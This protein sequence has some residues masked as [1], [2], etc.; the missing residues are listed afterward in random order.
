MSNTPQPPIDPSVS[1]INNNSGTSILNRPQ[2]TSWMKSQSVNRQEE[3]QEQNKADNEQKRSSGIAQQRVKMIGGIPVSENTGLYVALSPEAQ[4]SLTEKERFNTSALDENSTGLSVSNFQSQQIESDKRVNSLSNNDDST[5]Q[6]TVNNKEEPLINPFMPTE[7]ELSLQQEFQ[8]TQY[9]TSTTVDDSSTMS[10]DS[11][12]I[13]GKVSSIF[14]IEIQSALNQIQSAENTQNGEDS[15]Y[16]DSNYEYN[17]DNIPSEGTQEDSDQD[18]PLEED[19]DY[20][21]LTKEDRQEVDRLKKRDAEV[22]AH[23]MAHLAAAGGLATGPYYEYQQGPDSKQYAVGGHV[24]IDT[25]PGNSPEETI[26]KAAKIRS[27]AMAPVEPSSQDRIVAAQAA[28][29]EAAARAELASEKIDEQEESTESETVNAKNIDSDNIDSDT[30]ENK[31]Y[32]NPDAPMFSPIQSDTSH[33]SS[34]GP[35][36]SIIPKKSTAEIYASGFSSIHPIEDMEEEDSNRDKDQDL[37]GR[38]IMSASDRVEQS[39]G[40]RG[41]QGYNKTKK[42]TEDVG[43]QSTKRYRV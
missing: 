25:S 20:Q 15:N 4:K 6:G 41:I 28:R 21:G 36:I 14:D 24:N 26:M 40:I 13:E 43:I 39:R 1:P 8:T 23:E 9:N 32:F 31:S 29:M 35:S 5:Q 18:V 7:E 34:S 38:P 17:D 16:D 11:K 30:S 22:R 19:R 27:A 33:I 12:T 10:Q 42:G 2:Y 37:N 3:T